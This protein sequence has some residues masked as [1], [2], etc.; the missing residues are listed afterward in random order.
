VRNTTVNMQLT[1]DV[2]P[3]ERACAQITAKSDGQ[4]VIANSITIGTRV[5][6]KTGS[7]WREQSIDRSFRQT[8]VNAA[9]QICTAFKGL[10]ARAETL[11]GQ[12][13][14]HY[15]TKG[16]STDGLSDG[17]N[18]LFAA[19]SALGLGNAD[20]HMQVLSADL[21]TTADG[22]QP[23]RLKL[24]VAATANGEHRSVD[25]LADYSDIDGSDIEIEPPV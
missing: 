10:P 21:W 7:E 2:I 23:L 14:V 24:K 5:W 8:A 3:P 13:A 18:Q 1:E 12:H 6:V 11:Q 17:F 25:A 20:I 9:M 22:A 19:F 15:T 16:A 4:T